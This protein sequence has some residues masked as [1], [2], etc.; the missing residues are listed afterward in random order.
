MSLS[1]AESLAS[2][3][4]SDQAK[5][6][7]SLTEAQAEQLKWDWDF[8]AR[9]EQILPAGGWLTWLVL[10]GRGFGKMIAD[11]T[12][13]PTP[14][15]WATMG[16]LQVGDAVLDEAGKPCR[17]TAKFSPRGDEQ[18]RVRFSDG[19][20][21]D[22]CA[23]HQWVTWTHAERKAFLRSPYEDASRFPADW[24][25]WRLKRRLGGT[26]LSES[27]V[28]VALDMAR[29]GMSARR[30]AIEL[31]VCRQALARHI[32]AGTFVERYPAIHDDA[33]GPQIRTT[34][35]DCRYAYSGYARRC[36][37][38]CIPCC[39]TLDLPDADLPVPPYTLGA[40]LGDGSSFARRVDDVP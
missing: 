35:G 15:G 5:I 33:P 7:D 14:S 38:H 1:Q 36:E 39:G 37:F 24:P 13:I 20:F 11:D 17:V 4:A 6:L 18:Y 25:K 8:W 22:A 28:V 21:I 2:L 12:P 26:D 29:A 16:V 31:G 19:S 9:P 40:W 32:L 23:D 34:R 3:P 30:V 27:V 10:A